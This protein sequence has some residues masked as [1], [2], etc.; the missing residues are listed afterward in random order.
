MPGAVQPRERCLYIFRRFI[1]TKTALRISNVTFGAHSDTL[2]IVDSK[3]S[4]CAND[5]SVGGI[6]TQGAGLVAF[7]AFLICYIRKVP[8]TAFTETRRIAKSESMWIALQALLEWRPSE[9]LA[10]KVTL[11]AF[12]WICC[13]AAIGETLASLILTRVLQRWTEWTISEAVLTLNMRG[14]SKAWW[15]LKCGT[16]PVH[17]LVERQSTDYTPKVLAHM[18]LIGTTVLIEPIELLSVVQR[19]LIKPH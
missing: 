8:W 9:M 14:S 15:V 11:V 10:S 12:Q 19:L 1:N 5:T 4:G 2:V 18:D 7:F 16:V 13:E 3:S 17:I 6:C